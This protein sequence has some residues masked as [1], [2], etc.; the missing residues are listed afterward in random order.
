MKIGVFIAFLLLATT[1]RADPLQ[2][3]S[4]SASPSTV[5]L[6]RGSVQGGTTI[7]IAGVG[8]N[9]NAASNQ[10]FVGPYPCNIPA[11]GAT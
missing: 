6:P 8:F 3:F 4:V 5:V 9:A 2:L 1:I 7:Y 11:A 10:V